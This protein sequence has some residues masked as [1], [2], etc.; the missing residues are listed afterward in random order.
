MKFKVVTKRLTLDFLGK[1]WK[2]TFIE[3]NPFTISDVKNKFPIIA[4]LQEKGANLSEGIDIMIS[5]LT[6][7]FVTGKAI[8]EKGE[9]TDL[10]KEDLNDLPVEVIGRAFSF[11]SQSETMLSSIPSVK[12]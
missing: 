7:K 8:D 11:L 2:D 9:L 5:L 6:D 3:F 10:K 12:S 4:K 1:D